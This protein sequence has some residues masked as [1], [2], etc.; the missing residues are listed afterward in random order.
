MKHMKPFVQTRLQYKAQSKQ[1]Q[2]ITE[3]QMT[4]EA[5]ANAFRKL[6]HVHS[7]FS[8]RFS[9]YSD[10]ASKVDLPNF[11]RFLECEQR[12]E[13][14][15]QREKVCERLRHYLKDVDAA[16]DTAEPFLTVQEFCDYLFSRENSIWDPINDKVVHDMTRPLS[17][18]W[19]ASS[20][21]TYLTGDQLK[22][23]SS[24]DA[25]ARALL[26]GCRCIELDCW[27]GQKRGPNDFSEIVIYH[28]YTMTSKLN[29]RD[30]LYT[31]RE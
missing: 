26:M 3:E 2:E 27:D 30:V 31:I 7:L 28:G 20:H 1:L 22:S 13:L 8:D 17:H 24:L 4:Y 14:F 5:F 6:V 9:M 21:N 12:D 29:L 15:K 25:Y 18:Y 11:L 19:V 23:E 10:D 16:R